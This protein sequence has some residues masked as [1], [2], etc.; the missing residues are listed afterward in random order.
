MNL[1][2]CRTG[3]SE[4]V[5]VVTEF[6]SVSRAGGFLEVK[7]QSGGGLVIRADAVDLY[8]TSDAIEPVRD[9]S[10]KRSGWTKALADL[11]PCLVLDGQPVGSTEDVNQITVGRIA[12]EYPLSKEIQVI[13]RAISGLAKAI[14]ADLGEE[15]AAYNERIEALV[16][17]GRAMKMEWSK[18]GGSDDADNGKSGC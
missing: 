4:I 15:F 17:E 16:G 5:Q 6:E 10:G 8:Y 1:V 12:R 13:R 7:S 2:I 14:D 11:S 18:K 9:T 3:S